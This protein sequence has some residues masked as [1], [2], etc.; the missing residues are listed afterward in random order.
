MYNSHNNT[1]MRGKDFLILNYMN[2]SDEELIKLI[3]QNDTEAFS[4]LTARYTDKARLVA[5]SF[6]N[7]SVEKDDLVQEGMIGF[8]SAVRS[9]KNDGSCSFATYASH[10]MKNR[11]LSVIRTNSSKKRIPTDLVIPLEENSDISE[12]VPSPEERFI[13][14]SEAEYISS[15]ISSSLSPQES[16]IFILYLTGLSYG[17]IAETVGVSAKAV[18]GALQRARKK[19]REKLSL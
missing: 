12:I 6:R 11:I 17:E 14:K 10:C 2:L 8:L 15:V 19:L 1:A 4:L 3:R 13:S 16:R 18:D 5:T 9:F 7:A